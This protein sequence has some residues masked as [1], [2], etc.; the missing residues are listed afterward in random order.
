MCQAAKRRRALREQSLNTVLWWVIG[1]VIVL[2]LAGALTAELY[3]RTTRRRE[4]RLSHRP[5]RRIEL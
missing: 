4:K 2:I 3:G 1:I 5:K